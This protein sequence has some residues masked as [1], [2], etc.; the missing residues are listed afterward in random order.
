MPNINWDC[1]HCGQNI[2][3][4]AEL[5]GAQANCPKC[6]KR[7]WVPEQIVP[8]KKLHL[9]RD[10]PLEHSGSSTPPPLPPELRQQGGAMS[11][12]YI[13]PDQSP[14]KLVITIDVRQERRRR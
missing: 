10:A 9:K 1:P 2:E 8:R 4:D 5:A 14:R 7:I 6:D 12:S 13:P 3:A 11:D